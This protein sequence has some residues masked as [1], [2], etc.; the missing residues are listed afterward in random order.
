[1][2]RAVPGLVFYGS[3]PLPIDLIAAYFN[4]LTAL[5]VLR[6]VGLALST[7]GNGQPCFQPP[8]QWSVQLL[9]TLTK[10]ILLD[11]KAA[12]ARSHFSVSNRTNLPTF[13][14]GRIRRC[15][16]FLTEPTE[17]LYRCA[18]PFLFVYFCMSVIEWRRCP[19]ARRNWGIRR[20]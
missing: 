8:S 18:I 7:S 9:S 20:L 5:A 1:L 17:M 12:I 11:S 10:A 16:K 14:N 19:H 4:R 13:T 3:Q 15:I 6:L 2:F